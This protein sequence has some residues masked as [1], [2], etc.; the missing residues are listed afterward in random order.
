MREWGEIPVGKEGY[1]DRYRRRRWSLTVKRW[2]IITVPIQAVNKSTELWGE[3][4]GEF[5]C[6]LFL[7]SPLF[8]FSTPELNHLYRPERLANSPEAARAIPGLFANTFTFLNGNPLNG[9]KFA[10][11]E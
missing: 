1:V 6:V 7:V 5:R 3:D 4:A 10:L 11:F 8:L 9:N 2:D